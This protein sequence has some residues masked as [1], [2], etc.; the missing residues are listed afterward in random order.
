[1]EVRTML[2]H[3][4]LVYLRPAGAGRGHERRQ[5]AS[6]PWV[7]EVFIFERRWT[8]WECHESIFVFG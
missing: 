7:E 2:T 4:W 3:W 8:F 5:Q 6:L 1:M